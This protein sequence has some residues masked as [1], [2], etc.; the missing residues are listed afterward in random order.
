[1]KQNE[2]LLVVVD[3]QNDFVTGSLGTEEAKQ[4]IDGA[5]AKINAEKG[6]VAYTLDTHFDDYLS[7]SE[8]RSLPVEH[9]IKGSEGHKLIP[10]LRS[11][12]KDAKSFEKHTF[13]SVE[14]AEYIRDNPQIRE[15]EL[16]GLCT[17]ICVVSN[18]LMIKAMRP[19]LVVKV[20]GRISAGTTVEKHNAALDTMESCQI[21]VTR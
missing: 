13:G 21:V 2:R 8:G 14:L 17:D 15:V 9:C 1:M 4:I 19:E 3:M 18:A 5:V 20:D 7:T 6:S 12:L 16:F 11:P 10:E